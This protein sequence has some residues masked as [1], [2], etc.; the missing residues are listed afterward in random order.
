MTDVSFSKHKFVL[1]FLFYGLL[2]RAHRRYE[3]D[4]LLLKSCFGWVF[5]SGCFKIWVLFEIWNFQIIVFLLTVV[6]APCQWWFGVFSSILGWCWVV[7][8]ISFWVQEIK[9]GFGL[10]DVIHNL[11]AEA[12]RQAWYVLP[13]SHICYPF[14]GMLFKRERLQNL[15]L[16][17]SFFSHSVLSKFVSLSCWCADTSMLLVEFIRRIWREMVRL[18]S[19][20]VVACDPLRATFFCLNVGLLG[21]GWFRLWCVFACWIITFLFGLGHF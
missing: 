19:S 20:E 12:P 1:C 2:F 5:F 17:K 4:F 3:L 7:L 14:C 13:R 10:V 15:E 9:F 16:F 18:G 8:W 21:S 11:I 6:T